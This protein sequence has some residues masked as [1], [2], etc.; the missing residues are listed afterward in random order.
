MTIELTTSRQDSIRTT[1][2]KV[3]YFAYWIAQHTGLSTSEAMT[4]AWDFVKQ[5]PEATLVTFTKS[6]GTETTRLVDLNWSNHYQVKG[7][8]RPLKEG[9]ILMVDLAKKEAGMNATISTYHDRI[10]KAA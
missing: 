8:G 10:K 5:H 7:T 3:C 4:Y 9:Q 2:Q 6:N 1:R